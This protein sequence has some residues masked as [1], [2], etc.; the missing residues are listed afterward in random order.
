MAIERAQ[1][2]A[3]LHERAFRRWGGTVK[4]IVLDNLGEVSRVTPLHS[5]LSATRGTRSHRSALNGE[6][7]CTLLKAFAQDPVFSPPT[8][9]L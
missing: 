2:W 9:A 3:E 4:A 1:I 8:T 5:P 7:W 6:S